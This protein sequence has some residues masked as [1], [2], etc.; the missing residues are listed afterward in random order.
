MVI[1]KFFSKFLLEILLKKFHCLHVLVWSKTFFECLL[2]SRGSNTWSSSHKA[3]S[4]PF[5]RVHTLSDSPPCQRLWDKEESNSDV[6]DRREKGRGRGPIGAAAHKTLCSWPWEGTWTNTLGLRFIRVIPFLDLWP[7][8]RSQ[9]LWRHL[10]LT[11]R[12]RLDPL[13]ASE[14]FTVFTSPLWLD[15]R[16]DTNQMYVCV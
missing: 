7:S 16:K 1:T 14:S 6:D 8:F 5:R 13:R 10:C 3:A 12:Q 2:W 11:S 15:L 9:S 4:S